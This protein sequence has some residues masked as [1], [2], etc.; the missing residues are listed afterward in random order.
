MSVA[1]TTAHHRASSLEDQSDAELARRGAA[2]E[3]EAVKLITQ[4]NNRRLYRVAWSIL[5]NDQEAEEIVQTTYVRAFLSMRSFEGRSALSTWLTRMCINEALQRRR[6]IETWMKRLRDRSVAILDHYRD[7]L[8]RGSM[9]LTR[10]DGEL[11][12][13][14]VR[15]LIERAIA[16]LP[17]KL[18]TVFTLREIEE[19]SIA[20]VAEILSIP[21]ATVKTRHL[22]SRLKLQEALAPELR[23]ILSETLPFAGQR[24]ANMTQKVLDAVSSRQFGQPAPTQWTNQQSRA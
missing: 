16:Q 5:R 1:A 11:A 15:N 18:R 9:S 14:Q 12:R 4:R 22:R 17:E 2:G 10:P 8:M 7:R 20:E 23:E 21:P 3:R 6:A 13:K 19:M 24:C